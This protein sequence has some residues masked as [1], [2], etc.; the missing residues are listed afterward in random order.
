MANN[1]GSN[2]ERANSLH[3]KPLTF[4]SDSQSQR[5]F[6]ARGDQLRSKTYGTVTFQD[7][8]GTTTVGAGAAANDEDKDSFEELEDEMVIEE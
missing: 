8:K 4:G 7:S 5:S 6:S 2:N 1:A 3:I